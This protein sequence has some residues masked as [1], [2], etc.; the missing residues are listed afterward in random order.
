MKAE[1]K[2]PDYWTPDQATEIYELL[3]TMQEAIWEQYQLQI[4][5]QIKSERT[6]ETDIDIDEGDLPF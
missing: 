4:M 6:Y 5:Q 2:M 1:F 3:Q